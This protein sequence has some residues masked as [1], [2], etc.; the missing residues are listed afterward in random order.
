[1]SNRE[2][3]I[4]LHISILYSWFQNIIFLH[5]FTMLPTLRHRDANLREQNSFF[6][7]SVDKG[8][9]KYICVLNEVQL[10]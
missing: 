5:Y 2:L 9:T 4:P 6:T 10:G 1:M 8:A 3:L 7:I